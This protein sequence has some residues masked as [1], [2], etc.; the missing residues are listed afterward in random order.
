M[1][2]DLSHAEI[3]SWAR[4]EVRTDDSKGDF[5]GACKNIADKYDYA[6]GKRVFVDALKKEL[7]IRL[8][9][10]GFFRMIMSKM[11]N[12]FSQ[13]ARPKPAT[14][15]QVDSVAP[16][17]VYALDRETKA[18]WDIFH[19]TR[20]E[21][22]IQA[23][24]ESPEDAFR[25]TIEERIEKMRSES[26][27]ITNDDIVGELSE[28]IDLRKDAGNVVVDKK[29]NDPVLDM[30]KQSGL[31]ALLAKP[32][33]TDSERELLRELMAGQNVIILEE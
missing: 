2:N 8:K 27:K 25:R 30:T 11:A 32:E 22:V 17:T 16:Q 6:L 9:K 18:I 20:P 19:E 21:D 29:V 12:V 14:Q 3:S 4:R 7:G 23:P 26:W 28:I 24:G 33:L 13:V 5:Q 15:K 31:K 10:Q 1:G